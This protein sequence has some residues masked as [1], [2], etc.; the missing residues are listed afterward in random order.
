MVL[1]VTGQL[2][3]SYDEEFRR[4]YARSTVPPLQALERPSHL[5]RDPGTLQSPKSSQ[6]SLHQLRSRGARRAQ[7]DRLASAA[8]MTRGL[9]IQERLHQSHY[10]D[11][12]VLVRGHSYGED[13]QRLNSL[14][15]LRM[16]TKELGVPVLA[17][18]TGSHLRGVS[19]LLLPSRLSQQQL[20]HWS[21][22]GADQN[23]IPFNSESSLHRWK[24]DTYLNDFDA[25]VDASCDATSPLPSP[26]SSHTGLN[27][28][29]SQLIHSRS[30]DIKSRMEEIRQKRRSLQDYSNFRQNQELMRHPAER[31]S[32]K[33]SLRGLDVEPTPTDRSLDAASQ[34]DREAP[35]EGVLT[36]DRRATSYYDVK[37]LS[38][39]KTARSWNEPLLRT[40]SAGQ[41]DV[42]LKESPPRFSQPG[43]LGAPP[44]KPLKSLKEIPEEKE[45]SGTVNG[46]VVQRPAK[47]ELSKEEE[48]ARGE[49]TLAAGALQGAVQRS[50]E[51]ASAGAA[52][53]EQGQ[54]Q[55]GE[56]GLQRK[57]SLRM[58][59]Y[60][61]LAP[62]EKK[63]SKKEDKPLPRKASLK[64]KHASGLSQP[65]RADHPPLCS[66]EHAARKSQSQGVSRMHNPNVGPSDAEKH[67]PLQRSSPQRSSKKK[68]FLAAEPHA[69]ARS[70]LEREEALVYQTQKVYSR[71]EYLL[72][73]QNLSKDQ[74]SALAYQEP[75]DQGYQAQSAAD[76][77]LGKF[78]QRVGNLIG[79]NK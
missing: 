76:R 44:P 12:G 23:L 28:L 8:M 65:M 61:F 24:M 22:Y 74:S 33:S 54:A 2:V 30:R 71:F 68:S 52:A 35:R 6:L 46:P 29:Q 27:E 40:T 36:D 77:K 21:R 13:L 69:G 3:S 79:K 14:T 10:P 11:M 42:T 5:L 15:R 37:T 59:M 34:D 41:L 75:A 63:P 1:V 72:T 66:G 64:P 17:E 73:T 43:G 25:P 58:K 19:D 4:L 32:F 50:L 49:T 57:N 38:D 26:F 70:S 60:S 55:P 51:P 78:M 39:P 7:E 9:S 67:K 16:G 62:E 31:P 45:G 48:A 47:E 20:K 56:A 18:K 53:E